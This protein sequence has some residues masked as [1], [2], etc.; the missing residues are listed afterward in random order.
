LKWW[1]SASID[2]FISP[3][4][5]AAILLSSGQHRP[6][7]LQAGAALLMILV[8]CRISSMRQR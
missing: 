8:D 2:R 3:R 4:R 6:G 7:V 1:I 5:A